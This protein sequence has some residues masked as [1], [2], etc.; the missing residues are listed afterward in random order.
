MNIL[1]FFLVAILL[2]TLGYRYY[3]RYIAKIL[4]EDKNRPTPAVELNDG[5]DYCPTNSAVVFAHHFASIA[6]AGPIIGPTI[7]IM[8][9][10]IPIWLWVVIGGIFIGAVHDYTTLFVSLRERGKSIA[11]IARKSLGESGF[12]LMIVFTIIMILLV[13]SAFLVASATS[14]TSLVS[15]EQM[16]LPLDQTILHTVNKDGIVMGKI[17][18]IASTSVIIIT[19]FSP[20]VGFLNYKKSASLKLTVPL[21]IAICIISII[22]GLRFPVSL[23][24]KSWMILLSIYT[25]FASGLPVWVVLQPRDFINVYILYG[26][27]FL[28]IAGTI[29]AGLRGTVTTTPLLNINAGNSAPSLGL[30]W[31]FLFITV[32]CGA[33]SGFHALVAGGTVSKQVK[34]EVAARTIGYGGMLL[35]S[36]LAVGVIIALSCGIKFEEYVSIVH[37]TGKSNP[38]LAF[39]IAMSGLLYKGLN[40]PMV[41]GTIFGILMV[42]GF[43]ATSLDTAVRI[44]RYLFEELWQIIFKNPPL[45]LKSYIFNSALSVGLMLILAF[46]NAFS[47]IWP[48]F[49]TA[50]QLLAA[51]TLVTLAVWLATNKKKNRYVIIPAFFMITTTLFAL[52]F[53]AKR[54]IVRQNFILLT[55]DIIM[56]IL[57]C[58]LV[59]LAVSKVKTSKHNNGGS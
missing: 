45:W 32:A 9:G 53:L 21:A 58:V 13:T 19:L 15:L 42:E 52:I 27:L 22:G 59:Y 33:I 37:T 41:Y 23:D 25:L 48:I 50:N 47:A 24:V 3:S 30:I 7:A 20:L 2:M 14:L 29:G 44:N 38:I 34:S 43:V 8:Y 46:T 28:L 51:L 6:G 16:K 18:G 17:G 49:G 11:E 36:L 40:I 4:G 12:L 26:G 56:I 5:K 39:S 55:A 57:A 35:E 54:Y 10:V 1:W 31:P